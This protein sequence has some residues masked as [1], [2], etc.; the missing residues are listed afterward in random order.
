MLAR[1]RCI[2]VAYARF[3]I[4]LL[5]GEVHIGTRKWASP[6]KDIPAGSAIQEVFYI[7]A[8]VAWYSITFA[9]FLL[10]LLGF[11]LISFHATSF[12]VGH[13]IA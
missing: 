7:L 3:L 1:I 8:G 2:T 4:Y 5:I 6:V 10:Q 13:P 9:A 11:A 12:V